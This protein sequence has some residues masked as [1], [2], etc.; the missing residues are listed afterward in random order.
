VVCDVDDATLSRR[1]EDPVVRSD[2]EVAGASAQLQHNMQRDEG[3][4]V[5][6]AWL[7]TALLLFSLCSQSTFIATAALAG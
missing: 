7:L 6:A 5:R 4:Y 3:S 2:S 1:G